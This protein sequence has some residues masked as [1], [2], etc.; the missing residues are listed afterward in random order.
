MGASSPGGVHIQQRRG[1]V[2]PGGPHAHS[3]ASKTLLCS[4]SCP[5]AC[6]DIFFSSASFVISCT[7]VSTGKST[8][9]PVI[10][11]A[12]LPQPSHLLRI[13][14][15][16]FLVQIIPDRLPPHIRRQQHQ[17]VRKLHFLCRSYHGRRHRNWH[18]HLLH[19]HLWGR[20]MLPRHRRVLAQ[21]GCGLVQILPRDRA[22]R[23]MSTEVP[24]SATATP[25][26]SASLVAATVASA[27]AMAMSGAM[28][29][30]R[31]LHAVHL[32]APSTSEMRLA[33]A[34]VL[35]LLRRHHIHHI[36]EHVV[37]H[38][39]DLGVAVIVVI[40]VVVAS[41]VGAHHILSTLLRA[42]VQAH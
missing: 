12:F 19:R 29:K 9:I 40:V 33:A 26:T 17:L 22:A 34:A 28:V 10:L 24:S 32:E 11:A 5:C 27:T 18:W 31:L 23:I 37:E 38:I 6:V 7:A 30:F 2:L 35:A 20:H 15:R 42:F 1:V 39:L 25:T 14:F 36:A 3:L 13:P 16:H 21:R 8:N 4:I 41:F